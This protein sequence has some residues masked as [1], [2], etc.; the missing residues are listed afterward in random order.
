M[1]ILAITALPVHVISA[2]VKNANMQLSM[3]KTTQVTDANE[4]MHAMASQ[5]QQ[6]ATTEKSCCDNQSHQC[7]N[8]NDCPQAVSVMVLPMQYAANIFS[9]TNTQKYFNSHL[10]LSGNSQSNLLRPPRLNI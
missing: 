5:K 8:C 10:T 4:C 1:T 3:V 9:S 2:N 7:Q 6:Q